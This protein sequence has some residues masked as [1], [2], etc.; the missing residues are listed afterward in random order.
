MTMA[1]TMAIKIDDERPDGMLPAKLQAGQL[2]S[3]KAGPQ[4]TLG[5]CHVATQL[6]ST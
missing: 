3:T 2:S 5:N 6:A 4:E 1:R